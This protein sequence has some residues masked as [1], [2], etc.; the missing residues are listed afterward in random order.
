MSDYYYLHGL[1]LLCVASGRV[2]LPDEIYV[3]PCGGA[4]MVGNLA[5]LFLGQS[6][7]PVILLDSDNAGRVRRDALMKELY[8]GHVDEV[9]MLGDVLSLTTDCEI[10]DLL[11]EALVLPEVNKIVTKAIK[12]EKQDRA[13]GVLVDQIKSAAERQGVQLPEGW[14]AEVSRRLVTQ[15]ATKPESVPGAVLDKAS[16]LFTALRERFGRQALAK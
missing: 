13:K 11:G 2:G 12:L 15:W 7:R 10:E 1:S 5:A 16:I 4:K 6:V 14:K 3:T 8:V 9:V